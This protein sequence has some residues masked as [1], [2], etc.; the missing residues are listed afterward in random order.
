M[1]IF[2]ERRYDKNNVEVFI[3]E[4]KGSNNYFIHYN[5]TKIEEQNFDRS[6][7]SVKDIK[8]FIIIPMQYFPS[9]ISAFVEH[10]NKMGIRT[11]NENHL[12]GKLEATE[13]HLKDLQLISKKLLKIK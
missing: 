8:P 4:E 3:K 11:E 13:S 6:D 5:G 12:K 10:A 2:I 1:E 7:N 9:L